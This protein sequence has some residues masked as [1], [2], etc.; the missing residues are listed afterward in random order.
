MCSSVTIINIKNSFI[1][2]PT[3][4]R[5]IDTVE[6]IL[7]NPPLWRYTFLSTP[8][9]MHDGLL[10]IALDLSVRDWTEI[11]TGQK[12]LDQNWNWTKTTRPKFRLAN[13]YDITYKKTGQFFSAT[14]LSLLKGYLVI[15]N[16]RC[17]LFNVKLHFYTTNWDKCNSLL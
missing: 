1:N 11:Q 5:Y 12:S 16:C 17:A 6:L 14:C 3:D 4:L 10:Y 2:L 13:P 7:C 9:F 8:V 15:Y